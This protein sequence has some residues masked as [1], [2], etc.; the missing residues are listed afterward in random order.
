MMGQRGEHVRD[1][2]KIR[3]REKTGTLDDMGGYYFHS[4]AE[5]RS[6]D[7]LK[8]EQ[9]VDDVIEAR[10]WAVRFLNNATESSDRKMGTVKMNLGHLMDLIVRQELTIRVQGAATLAARKELRHVEDIIRKRA[11]RATT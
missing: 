6:W 9:V 5:K 11:N 8:E 10:A 4:R 7:M 2:R 1:G 3:V